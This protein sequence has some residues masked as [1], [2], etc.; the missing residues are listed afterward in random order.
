MFRA[1]LI[2]MGMYPCLL[3]GQEYLNDTTFFGAD[4]A[5]IQTGLETDSGYYVSGMVLDAANY[6]RA[7]LLLGFMHRNGEAEVVLRNYDTLNSQRVAFWENS[8]FLN[9]RGNFV[10]CY[11]NCD[12][13]T[14]YPRLKEISPTGQLVT[15]IRYNALIESIS[16]TTLDYGTVIQK[17]SDSSYVIISNVE[18]G[19]ISSAFDN[20]VMY[21]HLDK[22]FNA[23]DTQFFVSPNNS[24]S[25]APMDILELTNGSVVL[26]ISRLRILGGAVINNEIDVLFITLDANGATLD[27]R[28]YSDGPVTSLPFA[29]HRCTE[30]G[31]LFAYSKGIWDDI[32]NGW[33]YENYLCR[34][35]DT[36]N[37]LWKQRMI[38]HTVGLE[39]DFSNR[40]IK[41][42]PDG[43]YITAGGNYIRD[44][45]NVYQ[46]TLQLCKFDSN[47]IFLWKRHH[48]KIETT[49]DTT[50]GVPVADLR[51]LLVKSDGGYAMIATMKD[52]PQLN[53]GNN[54]VYAY[55]VE[56]NCLGFRGTPLAAASHTLESN[57]GVTFFNTSM[58]AGSY[59][60]I[61]GDGTSLDT[62]E[63]TD[64]IAH[65]YP[66]DGPYTVR[67]IARGCEQEHDTL[68]FD[69]FPALMEDS[70]VVVDAPGG[71][72][73]YP[74][75]A[76]STEALHIYINPVGTEGEMLT[77]EFTALNG[78]VAARY[79][80]P[81][82][83]GDFVLPHQ[84]AQ[85]EYM[86]RI[87]FHDSQLH[88]TRFV[89]L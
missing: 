84:L 54:G 30:G 32:T 23:L 74:N 47:G 37:L 7:E 35:D 8:M 39:G 66:G 22:N 78:S 16:G 60:W 82:E 49:Q 86:A 4:Y 89:V 79:S 58:Q 14:C 64:T 88:R 12:T 20:G 31:Y 18:D 80:L 67:L 83:G 55:I 56:T 85:G 17:K 26:M 38:P 44:S 81:A 65:T 69:V 10:T 45:N 46:R 6:P 73:I 61:F 72:L 34:V 21:F 9:D 28:Y 51:D 48:Y 24:R 63:Y 87:L 25:Y 57:Y 53:L 41:S 3:F 11:T 68:T 29:L 52:Y 19:T 76:G 75:P 27:T 42:T 59:T 40:A 5:Y 15:D 71:F 77:L 1:L 50:Y 36:F 70:S 13:Q 43:Y 33:K 2:L 62:D